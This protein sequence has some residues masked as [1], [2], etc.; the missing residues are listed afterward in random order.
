MTPIHEKTKRIKY[1]RVL[2][3]FFKR[4][5]SLLKLENFDFELYKQRMLKN[6]EELQKSEAVD[7]N[8]NYLSGLK[9]HIDNVMYFVSHGSEDIEESKQTL[10]KEANLLLK[11]KN[12]TNY[13]K[14]KHKNK[15][16]DDGY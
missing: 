16:F 8:S 11:D 3:K 6:F 15:K 14:D 1:I 13:K 9:R 4:N 2:E 5:I 10:L 12:Q 7:L